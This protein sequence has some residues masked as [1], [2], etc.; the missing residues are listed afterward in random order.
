MALAEGRFCIYNWGKWGVNKSPVSQLS[1]LAQVNM[2]EKLKFIEKFNPS[3]TGGFSI[4]TPFT[5]EFGFSIS[6]DRRQNNHLFTSIYKFY[7]KDKDLSKE[8]KRKPINIQVMYGEKLND[9]T[10]RLSPTSVK[11]KITWPID[12]F[13]TD[14]FFYDLKQEEFFYG[15]KKITADQILQEIEILHTKPTKFWQGFR[16]RGELFFWRNFITILTKFA[17]H[18]L[19]KILYIISGTK[20]EKSIWLIT[21]KRDSSREKEEIKK[22]SFAQEKIKIFGYHASA[23]SV[24]VYS[25]IH[26]GFYTL[27]YFF[28]DDIKSNFIK[29]I[30]TNGFLTITYVIPSLVLFERLVPRLIEIFIK[31][32]GEFFHIASFKKVKI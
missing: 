18:L 15:D 23:W 8:I 14:E 22:E 11:R 29:N 5:N 27:W 24:V 19:I 2:D 25:I 20:T 26:L 7:I 13:S 31:Y 3:I 17:Y 4:P 12:L 32:I 21:S 9:G 6:K 30:F 1:K 28:F 16:L 10:V